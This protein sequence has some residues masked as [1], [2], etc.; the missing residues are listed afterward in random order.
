MKYKLD[1]DISKFIIQ[2]EPLGL[3]DLWVD[4]LPTLTF[5]NPEEAAQAVYE[6]KSGYT[7]WDQLD[8]PHAPQGLSGWQKVEEP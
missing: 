6:Q 1:T 2:Q 4:G 3:W 8:E 5:S 7:I